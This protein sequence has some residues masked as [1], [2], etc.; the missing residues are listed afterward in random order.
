MFGRRNAVF[1]C[2]K[3]VISIIFGGNFIFLLCV[4]CN[5]LLHVLF[6]SF[7]CF[8]TKYI[9]PR[10]PSVFNCYQLLSINCWES[11]RCMFLFNIQPLYIWCLI[12]QSML[13]N[14][15]TAT[16]HKSYFD[17]PSYICSI[18]AWTA[19]RTMDFRRNQHC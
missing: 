3:K 2:S 14:D 13:L 12:F 16:F 9:E 19:R 6:T 15:V 11:N 17:M 5:S 1:Y 4:L 10:C 18:T 7:F 8:G